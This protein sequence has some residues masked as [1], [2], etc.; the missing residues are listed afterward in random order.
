MQPLIQ[1]PPCLTS[2]S[3][4]QVLMLITIN[5]ELSDSAL[6]LVFFNHLIVLP[7]I[8]IAIYHNVI[9]PSQNLFVKKWDGLEM[10][11]N[12]NIFGGLLKQVH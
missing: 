11:A 12:G 8:T 2:V 1:V 7:I 5:S 4:L 9:W 3:N 10:E 6:N